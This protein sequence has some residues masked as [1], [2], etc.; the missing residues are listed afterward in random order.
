[1]S[2]IIK[3]DSDAGEGFYEPMLKP[4]IEDL[5]AK[6][7]LV[8]SEGALVIPMADPGSK[9]KKLPFMVVKSDGATKYET[10]DLAAAIYRKKTYDF[11]KNLYVVDVRQGEHFKNLFKAIEG[12]APAE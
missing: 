9:K 10:R 12:A 11:V 6:G 5:K 7:V 2:G 4:L 8:E 1:M 3:F